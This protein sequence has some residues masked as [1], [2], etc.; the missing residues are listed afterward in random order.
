MAASLASFSACFSIAAA[1]FVAW[2]ILRSSSWH[3][4]RISFLMLCACCKILAFLRANALPSEDSHRN[5]VPSARRPINSF[6]SIFR[7]S[8]LS[9]ASL[10]IISRQSTATVQCL[11]TTKPVQ[12]SG[13]ALWLLTTILLLV[14]FCFR[15]GS[16]RA[17]A[18]PPCVAVPPPVFECFGEHFAFRAAAR[19][20]RMPPPLTLRGSRLP[21][22]PTGGCFMLFWLCRVIE[23]RLYGCNLFLNAP[24]F[25]KT[26]VRLR[27]LLFDVVSAKFSVDKTVPKHRTELQMPPKK[28]CHPIS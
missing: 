14:V 20:F 8:S 16:L 24:F 27:D 1:C 13:T 28:G 21:N 3:A 9:L 19:R 17:L 26:G 7:G 15:C 12:V 2:R 10:K 5:S 22:L 6:W 4:R 25:D 18:T 23:W 11:P